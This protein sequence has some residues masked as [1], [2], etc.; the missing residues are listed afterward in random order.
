MSNHDVDT[1]HKRNRL[2]MQ[3]VHSPDDDGYYA[4]IFDRQGRDVAQTAVHATLSDAR[5]AA[6]K[7]IGELE[8]K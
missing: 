1:A 7:L 4:D 5:A 6:V 8:S 2:Y 3:I